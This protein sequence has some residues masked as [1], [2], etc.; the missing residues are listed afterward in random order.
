MTASLPGQLPDPDGKPFMSQQAMDMT[1]PRVRR[2]TPFLSGL[3]AGFGR[4]AQI[5]CTMLTIPV[6]ASALPSEEFGVWIAITSLMVFTNVVDLGVGAGLVNRLA[7]A[8][9]V[10]NAEAARREVSTAYLILSASG[11]FLIAL[12]LATFGW[13]PVSD[14]LNVKGATFAADATIAI[15]ATTGCLAILSPLGLIGPIRLAHNESHI[16]NFCDAATAVATVFIIL[17]GH[18]FGMGLVG[19]VLAV[20]FIPVIGQTINSILF[21]WGA[22]ADLLPQLHAFDLSSAR[23]LLKSGLL[24]MTIIVSTILCL[25]MDAFITL[26]V[27]GPGAAAQ[28]GIIAKLLTSLQSVIELI[29]LPYW[30]LYAASLER[31]NLS[32]VRRILRKSTAAALLLSFPGAVAIILFG[33]A[34]VR[35]WL[36][37]GAMTIPQSI[38]LPVGLWLLVFAAGAGLM[39]CTR[40]KP[41]LPMQAGTMVIGATVI[42]A[43]KIALLS[44]YGPVGL[45]WTAVIVYP[46][47][48]LI[49]SIAGM[50]LRMRILVQGTGKQ[51]AGVPANQLVDSPTALVKCRNTL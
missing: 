30:P 21:Y 11:A 37:D 40:S 13:M 47:V 10:S 36:G 38:Y 7:A 5:G 46:L 42:I 51:S 27:A 43:G 1:A 24:F 26:K 29:V 9:A 15:F 8:L 4:F 39:C 20:V 14:L 45:V 44:L 22:R 17:I 23:E 32:E 16:Q 28:I 49:P 41:F 2:A 31:G 12:A 25:R 33:D 34:I 48:V 6:V 18:I 19:M 3:V 50:E 35:L